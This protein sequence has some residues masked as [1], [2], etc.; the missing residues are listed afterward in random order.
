MY[1]GM[2]NLSVNPERRWNSQVLAA[3]PDAGL[4]RLLNPSEEA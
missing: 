3:Q 2:S 1:S 4:A